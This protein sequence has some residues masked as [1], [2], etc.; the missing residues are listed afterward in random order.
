[1][2]SLG[3]QNRTKVGL[4]HNCIAHDNVLGA[5]Q[6]RTK[7]GLKL[8]EAHKSGFWHMHGKIEPRWD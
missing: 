8:V 3:G 6:N 2:S 4:K 7:V 1:L 5:R